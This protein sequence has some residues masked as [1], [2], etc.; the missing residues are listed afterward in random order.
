MRKKA[1]CHSNSLKMFNREGK[2]MRAMK[3]QALD[4]FHVTK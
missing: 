1:Y 2:D 4:L 3:K